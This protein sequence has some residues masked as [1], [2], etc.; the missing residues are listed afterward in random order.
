MLISKFTLVCWFTYLIFTLY[1]EPVLHLTISSYAGILSLP[2]I[3][4]I[5]YVC[6]LGMQRLFPHNVIS[7]YIMMLPTCLIDPHTESVWVKIHETT[8][9]QLFSICWLFIFLN[10]SVATPFLKICTASMVGYK[11]SFLLWK[12]NPCSPKPKKSRV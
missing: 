6:T 4:I 11:L 2:K 7:S 3:D 12:W 1:I 8:P 10:P 5:P 9:L